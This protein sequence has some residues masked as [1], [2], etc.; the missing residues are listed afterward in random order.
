[1]TN[2][3]E[4]GS[5]EKLP[6][7]SAPCP[8]K[9]GL[10][11]HD[12]RG[13]TPKRCLT[14]S[15]GQWP[16]ILLHLIIKRRRHHTKLARKIRFRYIYHLLIR[17]CD[18]FPPK[19][20]SKLFSFP[21]H[22]L[23]Y[24]I[25]CLCR[26]NT[27]APTKLVDDLG[28]PIPQGSPSDPSEVAAEETASKVPELR[29]ERPQLVK[30]QALSTAS[31]A[32]GQFVGPFTKTLLT[33]DAE[34]LIV[35][36][37]NWSKTAKCKLVFGLPEETPPLNRVQ[38][39]LQC[40]REDWAWDISG[41]RKSVIEVVKGEPRELL[42]TNW[43][44]CW[45]PVELVEGGNH[46]LKEQIEELKTAYLAKKPQ[47][48]TAEYGFATAE[49]RRMKD[50]L[51][52]LGD[53]PLCNVHKYAEVKHEGRMMPVIQAEFKQTFEHAN[54]F[55]HNRPTWRAIYTARLLA[56]QNL[57][58]QSEKS[59]QGRN[60]L[61]VGLPSDPWN[62]EMLTSGQTSPIQHFCCF[63]DDT[64]ELGASK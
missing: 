20:L 38:H 49:I 3:L 40:R 13:V 51:G 10:P 33:F 55:I 1:M 47:E 59:V 45:V 30:V 41:V 62:A 21:S 2:P 25:I 29:P 48:R 39:N 54:M 32:Q 26:R 58:K 44:S 36:P 31:S 15:K 9:P 56:L 60:S 50:H 61:E 42:L 6:P 14:T 52:D 28:T 24:Y 27:K 11:P 35:P 8:A 46:H 57:E 4:A 7:A 22:Y 16:K 43:A 12:P 5:D 18:I 37:Q 53:T 63:L 34:G 17:F 19:I 64:H 23:F